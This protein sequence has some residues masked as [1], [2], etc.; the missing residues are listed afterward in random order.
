MYM[1]KETKVT[2]EEWM[3]KVDQS[4]ANKC[5]L[6]SGDLEDVCYHDMYDDDYTPKDA[7]SE[8]LENA[9]FPF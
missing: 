4:I 2:F 8:A 3:N 6:S 5:G 9:G 7:A 1:P